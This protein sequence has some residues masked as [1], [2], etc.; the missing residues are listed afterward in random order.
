MTTF[1]D[2]GLA[3]P[4]QR[5]VAAAGYE[6]P[7]PVQAAA[8]PALMEGR[9]VLGIAQTGTGK[10]AAFVLPLL[11]QLA[12]EPGRMGPGKAR[13]LILAPTRE[14]AAQIADA[15]RTYGKFLRVRS[16][17][18]VGGAKAGPQLRA[19]NASP[20]VI[21]ATPGRLEDFMGT[22]AVKLDDTEIVVLDEADQMLDMGFVPAIRRILGQVAEPRQTVLFSATMPKPIK[23]LANE[24][25][26]EPETIAITPA[27]QPAN[28]IDQQALAVP[29]S[30]K[31]TRLVE[32]LNGEGAA[33][34]KGR[35]I[36][37]TRT[38]RGA[39]R[40]CD[41]LVKAGLSAGAIHG[42]RNQNQ[43]DR[44]L[45]AFRTG[46]TPIL[47]ATD[48]AARGIDVDDVALV[49]NYELPEVPEVYVHRIGR[50]GRAGRSGTAIALCDPGERALLR[51]IERLTGQTL[52]NDGQGPDAVSDSAG[53]R[54]RGKGRPGGGGR[55]RSGR[56]NGG[57]G[58]AGSRP[59]QAAGKAGP[60]H[61]GGKAAHGGGH[62]G[63]GHA[64]GAKAGH[65]QR[66]RA[67]QG[68]GRPGG[69][70][71]GQ[72]GNRPQARQGA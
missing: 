12:R 44:A 10:T 14:L 42:N 40:V 16:A 58:G 29:A 45:R 71:Q 25:Q 6:T 11:D 69:G 35:A 1:S 36:V 15:F 48:V 4:V 50:T 54:G 3:Q 60:R 51:D 19:L 31:R 49:V 57:Q 27:A 62:A 33:A 59:R 67:G 41:H 20:D 18:V 24:F 56:S 72:G 66:S 65:G 43:R 26:T 37:F 61:G 7:T 63:G 38:K 17:L 21:V 52:L 32:L 68:G 30:E 9:D 8:I 23:A 28:R 46:R 39:D 5:A 64:G 55:G 70:R 13:A 22:G 53:G 2:L 34:S 47:V